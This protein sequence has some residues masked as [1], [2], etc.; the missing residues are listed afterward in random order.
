MNLLKL[1]KVSLDYLND[2]TLMSSM[3]IF[4]L[5]VFD[6][7]RRVI[8]AEMKDAT[9]AGM[10]AKTRKE[11]KEVIDQ[12]LCSSMKNL[13]QNKLQKFLEFQVQKL[14][15]QSQRQIIL[16]LRVRQV[17]KVLGVICQ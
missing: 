2:P 9:R 1:K 12:M 11:E 6:R 14:V 17:T 13:V 16:S 4:V 10:T 3:C 5:Q 7:F 15:H 8:D